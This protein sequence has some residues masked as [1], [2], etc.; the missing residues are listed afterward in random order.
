MS[1]KLCRVRGRQLEHDFWV[2]LSYMR[3]VLRPFGR[4]LQNG[5]LVWG[6]YSQFK[7]GI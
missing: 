2:S 6:L 3:V 7:G 1:H 4:Y 5:R